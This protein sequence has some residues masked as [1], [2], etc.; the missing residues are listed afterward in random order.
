MSYAQTWAA[1]NDPD[2][3]GRCRAALWDIAR[4]VITEEN[5][6]PSGAL[7]KRI[8]RLILSGEAR[9]SNEQL[10]VLVLTDSVIAA[11]IPNSTDTRIHNVLRNGAWNIIR[12]I[13]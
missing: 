12:G 10:V 2:F 6:Y 9:I 8:A 4:Q 11:D 3:Q 7:N 1:S 13:G 5:G